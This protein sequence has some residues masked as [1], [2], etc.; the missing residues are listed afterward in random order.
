[1]IFENIILFFQSN[2]DSIL[3]TVNILFGFM[4]IPQLKDVIV[5]KHYLN[6]Y[7]CSFTFIGLCICNITMASLELWLSAMPICTILWLIILYF[8]WRNKK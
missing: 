4:L 7:T 2:A 5:K 3:V 8:S 6:L 1:M